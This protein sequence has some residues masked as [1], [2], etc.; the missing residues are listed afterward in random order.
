MASDTL[1]RIKTHH[2]S[3]HTQGIPGR[4]KWHPSIPRQ[5]A[6]GTRIL[7]TL[8]GRNDHGRTQGTKFLGV[9]SDGTRRSDKTDDDGK[10]RGGE[11]ARGL[12]R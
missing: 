7:K 2:S 4:R 12:A 8:I 1:L 6:D 3:V 9:K 11:C 5:T 10:Y